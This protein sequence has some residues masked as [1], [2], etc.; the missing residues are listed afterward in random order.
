MFYL[1]N[2]LTLGIESGGNLGT[3]DGVD[4]EMRAKSSQ[5]MV[6]RPK[7]WAW[8]EE[9]IWWAEYLHIDFTRIYDDDTGKVYRARISDFRLYG[10]EKDRGYGAEICLPLRYWRV[11]LSRRDV[12]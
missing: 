1:K 7:G 10:V 4:L 9:A 11:G 12:I 3:Y 2:H 6:R 8:S 5:D